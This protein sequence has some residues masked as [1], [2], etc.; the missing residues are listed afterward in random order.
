MLKTERLDVR[1]HPSFDAHEE[2]VQ[3]TDDRTG[4]K[5]V[6][7][8]HNTRLGPALG[9]CRF[10][11]YGEFD[12]ALTDVLRLSRGMT[13][14][15]ALARL[16]L[17]GGKAIII[18]DPRQIKTDALME[19][20]GA[21]VE[22]LQGRY[23]TAEDVGS[24]EHDMVA[25]SR[26]TGH[27]TGLPALAEGVEGVS[28]NPSPLTAYGCFFGIK[29]CAVERFGSES[30]DGKTVAIQG[31]GAVGYALAQYLVGTGARL[32]VADVHRD[33]LDRAQKE[34][35]ERVRI[36]EPHDI[37]AAEADILAPCALGA[38]LNDRTIPTLRATI[39]AGAAN[40]QLAEKRH[41]L[42]LK[43]RGIL[44][45]PDYA[46][47]SG[48]VTSVGYEYY[49]RTGRN[50][51]GHPLTMATMRQHVEKI[52][53]TLLTVFGIAKTQNIPTGLAADRLAEEIFLTRPLNAATSA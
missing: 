43:E 37:L 6:I 28:G 44:Y 50:P 20:F 2:V 11:P 46:I 14:K 51:F 23:V 7:A 3:F 21:A 12:E 49:W 39:V 36:V 29:A 41:D 31:M 10:F 26:R 34:F 15:S 30:L 19:S 35:G 5:A 22:S 47:N 1:S 24:N 9:G 52:E 4:L 40:N 33:A 53:A 25:I 45:A 48:G 17:G 18:G 38:I 32:I 27:V 8:I 13:Y 16:P 42:L